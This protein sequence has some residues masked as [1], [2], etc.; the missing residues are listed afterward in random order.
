MTAT[1]TQRAMRWRHA[2]QREI[3]RLA[4]PF[5]IPLAGFVLR[6]VY[7]YRIDRLAE[8]R[9]EFRRVRGD[10]TTPLLIC[11]NHLTMIDSLIIAWAL[12]PPWRYAIQFDVL[13]WNTPEREN[14][15][16]NV[17][18][19][20]LTYLAKCIP[21]QRGGRREE[22][23]AVLARVA[24]LLQRGETALLF[25]EGGR[26]RSGRVDPESA[27]WGVGRIVHSVPGCRVLCVYLRGAAQTSWSRLPERRDHFDVSLALIEPKTDAKG[28]RGSRE[29]ARQII[30]QLVQM[31]GSYF[32]RRR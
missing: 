1:G 11:A 16:T 26:S 31:E 7:G 21:I 18:D 6:F 29:L 23:A 8:V 27:A 20:V 4:A 30:A 5:W 32:A 13:P 22:V 24:H 9:S 10:S 28:A 3:G 15:A 14:F 2:V 25:P 19:R 17:R 12:F